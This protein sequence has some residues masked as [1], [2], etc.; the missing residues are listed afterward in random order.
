M[1]NW[2]ATVDGRDLS[3]YSPW[4]MTFNEPDLQGGNGE[5][6]PTYA[7]YLWHEIEG[8]YPDKYLVSPAILRKLTP[9]CYWGMTCRWLYAFRNEYIRLYGHAPRIDAMGGH[10]Y[11]TTAPDLNLM[12]ACAEMV[13][14]MEAQA[15]AWGVTGGLWINELGPCPNPNQAEMDRQLFET[16][17]YFERTPSI[18]RY[19]VWTLRLSDWPSMNALE[20]DGVELTSYGRVYATEIH[21][22]LMPVVIIQ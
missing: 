2:D 21:T 7:A 15:A 14:Y 18:V 20:C 8:Y 12:T 22:A 6:H 13:E 9:I 19:A 5:T 3:A 1:I 16:R 10:C 17:L 11:A 4:V